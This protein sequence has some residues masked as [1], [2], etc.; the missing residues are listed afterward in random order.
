LSIPRHSFASPQ[1]NIP[2]Q[3]IL[4]GY[5]LRFW[6]LVVVIGGATGLA[7]AGFTALLELVERWAWRR[8]A[9]HFLAAVTAASPARDLLVLAGAGALAGIGALFLRRLRGSGGGEVSEAIWLAGGRLELLGSLVRGVLSIVTVGMGASLG[10]EAAPQLAG[11]A[12]ASTL[13]EHSK[14][15]TQSQRRLLVAAGAGAGM[16]AV[17][18]VPLGGALFALEVLLGSLVLPLVLPALLTSLI[19]TAVAWIVVPTHATYLLPSYHVSAAQVVW[20]ALV[21]PLAG[22][23]AIAWVRLIAKANHARPTRRATRVLAP[24]VI[25]TAL[26][27]LAVQYPQLLGNGKELAQ[28]AFVGKLSLGLLAVLFILKPLV[29]AACLGSGAPGGLFTPTLALGVLFGALLGHAWSELWPGSPTGSYALIG[30]GA[31]LAA[32]M[33]GPLCATVLMLELTHSNGALTVPL[34]LAVGLATVVARLL[35]TPS[36][37]SARLAQDDASVPPAKDPLVD[38]RALPA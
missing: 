21:G 36:I 1:P 11:G 14:T 38:E 23:V 12:F 31:L 37:Y 34:L 13:C 10:R 15:I 4:A 3:G 35:A 18:N 25:F 24:I 5:T 29:T 6:G 2:G 22:L 17:Y 20:A 26:G 30:G 28:L 32:A 7:A 19:A 16:A 33:Q 8:P 27:A 9:S